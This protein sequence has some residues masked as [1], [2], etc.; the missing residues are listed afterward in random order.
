MSAT[1]T[2]GRTPVPIGGSTQVEVNVGQAGVPVAWA[3]V[4]L[5]DSDVEIAAH[6]TLSK[7]IGASNIDSRDFNY[8][9]APTSAPPA[10]FKDRIKVSIAL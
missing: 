6:G 10:N 7:T 3:L 9:I 2:L 1:F 4:G 5:D 8:Y